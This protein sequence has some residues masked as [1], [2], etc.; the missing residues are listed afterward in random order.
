VKKYLP[1]GNKE[2]IMNSEPI[3]L[4]IHTPPQWKGQKIVAYFQATIAGGYDQ[5]VR[6]ENQ[7]RVFDDVS[8]ETKGVSPSEFGEQFLNN[9]QNIDRDQFRPEYNFLVWVEHRKNKDSEWEGSEKKC[10]SVK[11]K[12]NAAFGIVISNDSGS[13]WDFNDCVVII[14]LYKGHE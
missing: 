6:I 12:I 10:E 13:D 14:S 5:R 2:K 8:E 3:K 9:K 4:K 1:L 11:I 7:E